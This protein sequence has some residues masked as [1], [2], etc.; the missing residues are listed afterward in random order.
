MSRQLYRRNVRKCDVSGSPRLSTGRPPFERPETPV[1]ESARDRNVSVSKGRSSRSKRADHARPR[2]SMIG[3][4]TTTY[5]DGR[6]LGD[7]GDPR[8]RPPRSRHTSRRGSP[9]ARTSAR[10]LTA[11]LRPDASRVG[12]HLAHGSS[13]R[14]V[15]GYSKTRGAA[16]VARR[17]TV[18]RAAAVAPGWATSRASPP[19]PPRPAASSPSNPSKVRPRRRRATRRE[20]SRRRRGSPP[21]DSP[22]PPARTRSL[23]RPS[24]RP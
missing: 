21:R 13:R 17:W 23:P 14:G 24:A 12:R 2:S 9:R 22:T 3:D 8:A 11:R 15:V 16:R 1:V 10:L 19:S 7:R 4:A 5:D 18:G 6:F 20:T